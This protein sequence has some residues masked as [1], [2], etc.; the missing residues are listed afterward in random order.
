MKCTRTTEMSEQDLQRLLQTN[1][2][3]LTFGDKQY[4]VKPKGLDVIPSY[5]AYDKV[6]LCWDAYY[7]D[8]KLLRRVKIYFFPEDETITV[9]EPS[10]ENSGL[11]QGTLVKRHKISSQL[12]TSQFIHA[13]DI[14]VGSSIIIYSKEFN[15]VNCDQ[16]TRDFMAEKFNVTMGAPVP[17]PSD[18]ALDGRVKPPTVIPKSEPHI[19]KLHKFLENDRKVL[20][21]FASW[22]ERDFIV[23]YYLVDDTVE[24]REIQRPNAGR[25]PISILLRRQQLPKK[26]TGLSSLSTPDIITW[27]DLCLG[28]TLDVLGRHFFL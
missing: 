28:Q 13:R 27:K 19:D 21:F 5:I 20:R 18:P 22:D 7:K 24:V 23:H 12:G 10:I 8:K 2:A 1:V 26:F 4:H 17:M 6:T 14:N 11:M 16:F 15:V 3:K 9:I 25:D